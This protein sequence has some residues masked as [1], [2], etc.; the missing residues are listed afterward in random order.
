MGHPVCE[1]RRVWYIGQRH[2]K[3]T[4]SHHTCITFD[5][6]LHTFFN[7][8]SIRVCP[9][10]SYLAIPNCVGM[11][12]FIFVVSCVSPSG[13]EEVERGRWREMEVMEREREV[14]EREG[15]DG[16]REVMERDGGDGER[17]G[18]DG[19]RGR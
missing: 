3:S 7:D 9:L 11:S 8:Y 4:T 1:C 6:H 16:E 14:M 2:L 12:A 5:N 13:K 10:K 15:G 19:E 18:G 17:K